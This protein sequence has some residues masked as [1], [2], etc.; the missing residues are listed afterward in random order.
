M[1]KEDIE[2]DL[3]ERDFTINAMGMK[4]PGFELIDILG[5]KKDIKKGVIRAVKEEN[6]LEDP[7]RMLRAFRFMALLDFNIEEELKRTITENKEKIMSSARERIMQELFIIFSEGKVIF[8]TISKMAETGILFV[9]IPELA[10]SQECFQRYHKSKLNVFEHILKC[11]YYLERFYKNWRRTFF[12]EY[13]E[14]IKE[15][16]EPEKRVLLFL[17]ILFH[18]IA[19]PDTCTIE[20]GRTKFY[21]HDK[22][23][24]QIAYKWAK[25]MRFSEKFS[26]KL[27]SLVFWHMYPHL[28][29]KEKER[30]RRAYHRYLRKTAQLWF[31]LFVHAYADFRATPPGKDPSY[32]KNL[33][34]EIYEF[35]KETEKERPKPLITGYDLIDLGLIPSPLF[36]KI[37]EEIEEMRAE[38]KIKEKQEALAYIRENYLNKNENN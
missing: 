18:D 19:K 31:L 21:G 34:K 32:L 3:L 5:G 7:L 9:L 38:G 22:I 20:E 36:R 35:K 2:K 27:S 13:E 30:T 29:G 33:L 1:I 14:L 8:K 28:L 23:G 15:I 25:K 10:K 11:V 12:K 17:G 4:I 16:F 6:I 24:A 37:L 26:K